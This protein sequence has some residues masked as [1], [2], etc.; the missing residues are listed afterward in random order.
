LVGRRGNVRER[1]VR[2]VR[3]VAGGHPVVQHVLR[4]RFRCT[5]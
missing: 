3:L 4:V 2:A 5:V 1:P